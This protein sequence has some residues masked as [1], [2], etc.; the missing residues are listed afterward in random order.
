MTEKRRILLLVFFQIILEQEGAHENH[1]V[2][3]HDRNQTVNRSLTWEELQTKLF[4][5]QLLERADIKMARKISREISDNIIASFPATEGEIIV[6]AEEMQLLE[7]RN[8]HVVDYV[9]AFVG[10]EFELKLGS[11]KIVVGDRICQQDTESR[12]IHRVV[13]AGLIDQLAASSSIAKGSKRRRRARTASHKA[14]LDDSGGNSRLST[15]AR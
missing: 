1:F 9:N 15:S 7:H 8:R 12:T 3:R 14:A 13:I 4:V 2:F 5:N 11:R 6:T 10:G